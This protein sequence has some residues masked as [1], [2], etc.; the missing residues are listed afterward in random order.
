MA[1]QIR[2]TAA[3]TTSPQSIPDLT[4]AKTHAG[5]FTQGQVGAT[6]T[7]T[8]R[9]LARA[10][11]AAGDGDRHAA[12]GIDGDGAERD[13]VD[14]YAGDTEL[15]AE[16]ALAAAA[17]YPVITLTVNVA[18]TAPA[19]VTNTANVSGGGEANTANNSANDVTTYRGGLSDLTV[20]KSHTGSFHARPDG[21][22]L[23]ADGHQQWHGPDGGRGDG[24]RHAAERIDGDGAQ[25]DGVDVHGGDRELY[26]ER[27]SRGRRELSGDHAD[28]EC[29]DHAPASV[30][31]TVTVG[32]GGEVNTR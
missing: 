30:T 1:K 15:H 26:A 8:V 7:L 24:D 17:S 11:L 28:G 14:V 23:H 32:G 27:C 13:R 12:D 3:R 10:R 19:S 18:T 4:V 20:A 2:R 22:D 16:H 5:R 31:N 21:R 29:L 9:M 25:R 6:Y